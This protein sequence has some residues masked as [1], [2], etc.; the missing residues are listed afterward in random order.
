[1]PLRL[2]FLRVHFQLLYQKVYY[3][4]AAGGGGAFYSSPKCVVAHGVERKGFG[5]VAPGSK[6]EGERI[7]ELDSQRRMM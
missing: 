2:D 4:D 3:L 1:M 5:A 7:K 6:V